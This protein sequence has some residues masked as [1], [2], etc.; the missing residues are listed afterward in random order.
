MRKLNNLAIVGAT[1]LVGQ[2]FIHLINEGFFPGVNIHLVASNK[3]KGKEIQVRGEVH[4]VSS[5]EEFNF[6][7]IDVA[8]FSAGTSTAEIY[9]PKAVNQGCVV[10]DNSSCFRYKEDVPLIVPEVNASDLNLG[11]FKGLVANP[12]CSTIQMLAAL[13][14]IHDE[15]IIK[16]IEIT[17]FQAVSGT[18][19]EAEEELISQS[20]SK[21]SD[22]DIE[23][24]SKVYKKPIAFNA[25]PQC[26]EFQ[27][28]RYTKEEMKL[29]WETKKI[30]DS[31]IE[32]NPTCARVPVINGHSESI[33]LTTKKE[34]NLDKVIQLLKETKGLSVFYG[35]GADDYPTALTDSDGKNNVMVG[36]LRKDL[37]NKN[38]LNLWVVADN[39][40][41]GAALNSFQI[42]EEIFLK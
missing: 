17:T 31:S 42:A 30:L 41:K 10:I 19:K 7:S 20:K 11:D 27:D 37:W 35:E 24:N 21:L 40:R 1:G 8:F 28:N 14:P 12:N 13:K 36:R 9:A 22:L 34:I 38:G 4:V 33:H 32:V 15:F 29:V 39:L 23:L 5:L 6:S 18:G 3:S 2:T 16:R 25:I 26:D